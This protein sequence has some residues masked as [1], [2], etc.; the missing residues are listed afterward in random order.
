MPAAAV[1][2][3]AAAD[4]RAI[5]AGLL[6]GVDTQR[7]AGLA[8]ALIAEFGSLAHVLAAGPAAQ[9]RIVGDRPALLACLA[10]VRGAMLNVLAADLVDTPL[11][12]DTAA[13]TDYLH[14]AMAHEPRE[15]VRALFLDASLRLIR[16]EV[17]GTGSIAA[18][19]VYPREIM[20]RA[21]ELGATGLVLA[22][23]HPSGNRAPSRS[24]IQITRQLA[25]AGRALDVKLH[26]HL[27]ITR[28]G[29]TSLRELGHV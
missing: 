12:N 6:A 22:H 4:G 8:D 1:A 5:L 27:I 21:L 23:N 19:P 20:R 24:D 10:L 14:V 9:A 15:Q 29:H 11:L 28:T 25:E 16:D 26:D 18:A 2:A 13:V 7:G 3:A 17:L